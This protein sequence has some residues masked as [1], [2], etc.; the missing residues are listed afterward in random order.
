[1]VWLDIGGGTARNL[2]FF[3]VETIRQNFQKIVVVDV[4]LSL[5]D[6][7]KKR[8]AAAGL[9]DIIEC[10]YC[11]FCDESQVPYLALLPHFAHTRVQTCITQRRGKVDLSC[12]PTGMRSSC[13]EPSRHDVKYW[14]RG[15]RPRK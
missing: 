2:E 7:A 10:I 8:V 15:G 14:W 3:S 4:S 11:D 6:V 9:G 1:M 13:T 5:L 12:H